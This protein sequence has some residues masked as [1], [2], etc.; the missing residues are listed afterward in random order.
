MND[1]AEGVHARVCASRTNG[2]HVVAGDV[3]QC[4]LERILRGTPRRLCLP[5]TEIA[6]IVFNTQ[7][8]SHRSNELSK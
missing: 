1:L 7:C 5:S 2:R 6:A 3:C 4:S 8:D